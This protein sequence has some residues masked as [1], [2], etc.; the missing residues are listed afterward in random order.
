MRFIKY[1]S[2]ILV[3]MCQLLQKDAEFDFNEDCKKAYDVLKNLRTPSP[4]IQPPDWSLPFEIMC[5]ASNYA[6]GAVLGKRKGRELD[7]EIR[8]KSEKENMVFDLLSR[9][10]P[11]EDPIL[12]RE[13]FPDEHLFAVQ[14]PPWFV[15]IVNYL[16]SRELLSDLT[17]AQKDKIKK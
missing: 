13:T 2:K 9:L 6:I 16:V 14:N 4:I 17:R 8:Y 15:D 3:P 7:I 1:F 10:T 5:D 12:I 11:P